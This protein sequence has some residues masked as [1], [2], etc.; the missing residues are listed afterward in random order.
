MKNILEFDPSNDQ[1]QKTIRRLEPLAAQKREKMKEEMIGE[2]KRA[3]TLFIFSFS[4][5]RNVFNWNYTAITNFRLNIGRWFF[6]FQEGKTYA[7]LLL[8]F[9]SSY[10]HNHRAMPS[11]ES[12]GNKK[13]NKHNSEVKTPLTP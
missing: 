2:L 4:S 7:F 13:K 12:K 5:D 8:L 1:A 10:T 6:H 11:V 3:T 9:P